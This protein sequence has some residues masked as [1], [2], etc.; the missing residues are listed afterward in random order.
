MQIV[1]ILEAK[2][3]IECIIRAQVIILFIYGKPLNLAFVLPWHTEVRVM[4]FY[5]SQGAQRGTS[6]GLLKSIC[7]R[8]RIP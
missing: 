5:H 7:M 8:Q 2:V 1:Y 3:S 4:G 6:S